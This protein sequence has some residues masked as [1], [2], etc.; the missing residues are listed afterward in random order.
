MQRYRVLARQK[1][2]EEGARYLET[3]RA[4]EAE[5]LAREAA[6]AG[7]PVIVV[8]GDGSVHEVVNGLLASGRR[9]PLGIVAAGSGNDFAWNT[10]RLPRDPVEALE[11]AFSGK[12]VDVD[13]GRVNGRYFANAF[14]VGLDADIAVAA[15]R[16]KRWPLMSGAR[17]YY[18]ASLRQLLFGYHHCPRLSFKLDDAE[19]VE[20]ER[21]VLLAVSNGPTYGGGFRI[22]PAADHTDGLFHVCVI[23]YVPLARALQL[24]PIVQRGEHSGVAE[25]RFFQARKVRIESLAPVHIQMDGETS[26]ARSYQAEILA[27]ALQVRV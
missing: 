22:N 9:V 14:S 26:G 25:A 10:L 16:L 12:L 4:G 21:Y 2:A 18:S 11:R 19:W 13:A 17:L 1:A 15:H 6:S 27:G 5:E 8:G 20:T 3:T 23:R 7:C 24:L